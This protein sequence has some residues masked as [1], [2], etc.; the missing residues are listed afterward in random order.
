[1]AILTGLRW[2]LIMVS[3]CIS[4]MISDVE[5]LFLCLLSNCRFSLDRCQF[6]SSAYFFFTGLFVF[7]MLIVCVHG[8][9]WMLTPCQMCHL[10]ISSLIQQAAFRLGGNFLHWAK[11]EKLDV[12]LFVYFI[13]C[14]LCLRRQIPKK[15][16]NNN[17]KNLC[18]RVYNL[19]FILEIVQFQVLHWSISSIF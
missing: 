8:I 2:Y 1:M 12:V 11:A 9:F 4:L 10:R 19:C 6:R 5:H 13:F 14:F 16:K 17:T 18:Q 15:K 7:L 3:I